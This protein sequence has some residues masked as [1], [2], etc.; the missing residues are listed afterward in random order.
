[1]KEAICSITMS[2]TQHLLENGDADSK[3][4][5]SQREP[6][7]AQTVM[8]MAS[9]IE[10]WHSLIRL[11]HI[12]VHPTNILP[13]LRLCLLQVQRSP[14]VYY[15]P[16]YT[17][18]LKLGGLRCYNRKRKEGCFDFADILHIINIALAALVA[19]VPWCSINGWNEV[20]S[21]RAIGRM[22]RWTEDSRGVGFNKEPPEVIDS[23][24][25]EM[26]LSLTRQI[27]RLALSYSKRG[28]HIHNRHG[29]CSLREAAPPFGF[30]SGVFDAWVGDFSAVS[31]FY[32]FLTD[33]EPVVEAV[34]AA[35]ISFKRTFTC[36]CE[37]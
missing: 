19:S 2:Q 36:E 30:D 23:L 32:K 31:V 18:D 16:V 26:V 13:S 29:Q 11:T 8:S 24:E 12:D 22:F 28:R 35:N 17:H 15:D 6:C 3:I 5:N 21:C 9:F 20:R 37:C 7:D 10:I 34:W 33:L 4:S 27:I 1:M 25:D 14:F